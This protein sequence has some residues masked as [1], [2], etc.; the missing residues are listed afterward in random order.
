MSSGL[1]FEGDFV[2][3]ASE[4]AS[5]FQRTKTGVVIATT[6]SHATVKWDRGLGIQTLPFYR[7]IRTQSARH[8][9]LRRDYDYES[10]WY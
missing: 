6:K 9:T 7:L 10:Y 5:P 4:T 2:E 1:L 3:L 8:D